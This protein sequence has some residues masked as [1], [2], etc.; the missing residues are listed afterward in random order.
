MQFL[1]GDLSI[2]NKKILLREHMDQMK[3]GCIVCNM[4][5]PYMEIDVV[6]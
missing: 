1:R 3:S 2:G 5:H 6:S 4:G